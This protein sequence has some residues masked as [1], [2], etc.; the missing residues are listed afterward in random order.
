[1]DEAQGRLDEA[2]GNVNDTEGKLNEPQGILNSSIFLSFFQRRAQKKARDEALASSVMRLNLLV[3]KKLFLRV[4]EFSGLI[5][6][7]RFGF[8]HDF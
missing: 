7:R 6:A 8:A 1:M 5:A 4:I 3:E 2:K